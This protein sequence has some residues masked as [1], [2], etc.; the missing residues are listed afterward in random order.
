MEFREH[1]NIESLKAIIDL[2]FIYRADKEAL[3]RYL[4]LAEKA[5]ING[6]PV[7]YEQGFYNGKPYGRYYPVVKC[8][9]KS[10]RTAQ[11]QWRHVRS[12]LFAETETDID[13]V[14]CHPTILTDICRKN[15][16]KCPLLDSYVVDRNAFITNELTITQSD[17][18]RYNRETSTAWSLKDFGKTLVS[19]TIYGMSNYKKEYLLS[20]SPFKDGKFKYE[21]N[22]ITKLVTSLPQ[23][24]ML[25]H[26]LNASSDEKRTSGSILSFILQ[27]EERKIVEKAILEFQEHGFEVTCVIHDG[28]QVKSK[29]DDKIDS[30]LHHLNSSIYPSRLIRKPFAESVFNLHFDDREQPDMF[31]ALNDEFNATHA[32]IIKKSI[33]IETDQNGD[34]NFYSQKDLTVS[35]ADRCY[36]DSKGRTQNFIKNWL[37]NN[38]K[39]RKFDDLDCFPP[40]IKCPEN[41]FNTWVDFPPE[42]MV[43]TRNTDEEIQFILNHIRVICN[44]AEPVY[45][46][47]ILWIAQMIQFPGIKTICITLISK[48]GAGKGSLL[49]LLA[50][51]VGMDKFFSTDKPSAHVWGDFNGKMD[52][53]FLVNL[54]ELEKSETMNAGGMIKRLITEPTLTINKKGI[55]AYDI[56]SY[57]RF[58]ITTNNED[59]IATSK[60]DRRNLI[61]RA[62]DEKCPFIYGK[63]Q[64]AEYFSTLNKYIDDDDV[65]VNIYNYFKSIPGA[66][67]FNYLPIPR[68]EHQEN[69]KELSKTPIELWL[70]DFVVRSASSGFDEI[71]IPSADAYGDFCTWCSKFNKDFKLTNVAFSV[72]LK[73]LRISGI[74]TGIHTKNGK[75][76]IFELSKLRASLGLS[77]DSLMV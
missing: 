46:C 36:T 1:P 18:D 41:W 11:F 22:R 23:Y 70:E 39:Q 63:E 20:G 13:L 75:Q 72:R 58:I 29:D 60:D 52:R 44:H 28:F 57:H 24:A 68:T 4:V 8:K 27:E 30:V 64:S 35:Y 66:D 45:N 56:K 31:L 40:G 10:I 21:I 73:N 19:A 62:S 59:P 2:P 67:K 17:V 6:V 55:N 16:I 38:P 54:D 15:K 14:N 3:G 53:A 26:D 77:V 25:V 74:T 51:L 47:V 76:T 61:I 71:K 34:Y 65:L 43:A 7:H 50:R 49:R 37:T 32:K 9:D 48:Q 69:L 12:A 42:R 5:G 33:F